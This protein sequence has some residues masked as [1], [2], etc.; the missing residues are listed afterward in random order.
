MYKETNI[1]EEYLKTLM[2][3]KDSL[4]INSRLSTQFRAEKMDNAK[5]IQNLLSI[6]RTNKAV[7]IPEET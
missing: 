2:Q 1:A 6:K 5:Y 3:M 7:I 4:L